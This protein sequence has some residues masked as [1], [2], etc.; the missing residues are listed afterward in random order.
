[1]ISAFHFIRPYWLLAL[2]PAMWVWWRVWRRHD[3]R[4]TWKQLIAPHLLPY[5]LTGGD[6]HRRIRPIHLLAIMWALSVLALA[7]PTWTREASPFAEDE[8]GMMVLL[9]VT[10]SM[11]ATDVQPTRLDRAKHKLRDLLE[12]R[13]GA[14]TGLI[15]YSGSAHLVMPLTRDRVIIN[16][17][18]EGLTPETMPVT[19]DDLAAALREAQAVLERTGR[20]GSILV[21]ADTVGPGALPEVGNVQFLAL[22]APGTRVDPGL[23][24]AVRTLDAAVTSLT[25]DEEDVTQV[26]RRADRDLKSVLAEEAGE[27]WKDAGYWLLPLI[28][29]GLVV[30]GRRG[31]VVE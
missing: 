13:E 5:L 20:S 7:G 19:G 22:H 4:S 16:T 8:A 25:V 24:T 31:W 3:A 17:M 1:M 6:D 26:N 21:M 12:V 9:K 28:A 27:R 11:M 18:A 2:V 14:A 30:W 15:A 29:L 23:E 10:P